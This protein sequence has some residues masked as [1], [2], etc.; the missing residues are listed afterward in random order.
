MLPL[1]GPTH[2]ELIELIL[3]QEMI[4]FGIDPAVIYAFEKTLLWITDD[5]QK[6]FIGRNNFSKELVAAWA[7]AQ[8][9]FHKRNKASSNE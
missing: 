1:R 6:D 2:T 3:I 4:K 9:E 8:V 5:N 7:N